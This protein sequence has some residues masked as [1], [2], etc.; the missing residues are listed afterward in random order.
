[1]QIIRGLKHAVAD[2]EPLLGSFVRLT[3]PGYTDEP[4]VVA[5]GTGVYTA[6]DWSQLRK[7]GSPSFGTSGSEFE[8]DE[9]YLRYIFGLEGMNVVGAIT[10]AKVFDFT[11]YRSLLEIGCGAMAQ[12]YVLH[13]AFPHLRYLAT[14][15]DPF[16]I[17]RCAQLPVLSG[18]EKKALNVL[19]MHDVALFNEVELLMSWGMEYALNDDELLRLLTLVAKANIPYLMCS[20]TT[21]GLLKYSM[22]LMR[23]FY[24]KRLLAERRLRVTGWHRSV[25]KFRSLAGATGLKTKILGR[26]GNHFCMLFAKTINVKASN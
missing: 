21:I 26:F 9:N 16:V 13:N 20:A 10:L 4:E 24:R 8:N 15:L 12:A 18:I 3:I 17:D 5:L 19:S 1:M 6:S 25:G 22:F 11:K 23:H 2:I 14:D 7:E